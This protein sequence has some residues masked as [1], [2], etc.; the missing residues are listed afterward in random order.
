MNEICSPAYFTGNNKKSLD[1][2]PALW[3]ITDQTSPPGTSS[4]IL[5]NK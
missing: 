4:H 2:W 1:E 5:V 3:T